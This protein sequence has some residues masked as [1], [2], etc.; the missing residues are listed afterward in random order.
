MRKIILVLSLISICVSCNQTK[1]PVNESKSEN[2][3]EESITNSE[4]II[5]AE[6]LID[7]TADSS[8][9]FKV[10]KNCVFFSQFTT[11]ECDSIEKADPEAYEIFSEN[12]NNNATDALELLKKLKIKSYWSDKRYISYD[13]GEKVYLIDTRLKNFVGN[14][15]ILFRKDLK[16]VIIKN[17]LLQEDLLLKYFKE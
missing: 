12:A 6:V 8:L 9:V 2:L 11:K 5:L 1:K 4:D 3:V 15:C 17:D 14:Y 7:K 13:S 16:P 10:T